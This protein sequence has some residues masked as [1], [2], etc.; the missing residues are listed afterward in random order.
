MQVGPAHSFTG[1]EEAEC[2][3]LA[4]VKQLRSFSDVQA[5]LLRL[6]PGF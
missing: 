3:N 4:Q 1:R 6:S 2:E 5:A